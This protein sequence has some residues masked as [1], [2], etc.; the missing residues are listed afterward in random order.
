MSLPVQNAVD[1]A[2]HN[3]E[4]I[5]LLINKKGFSSFGICGHCGHTL[6]CPRCDVHLTYTYHQKVVYCRYCAHTQDKPA[7]CPQCQKTY[8]HFKGGGIE[9]L[10]SEVARHF[11]CARIVRYE[12]KTQA[13]PHQADIVI[14]TQAVLGLLGKMTFSLSVAMQID[15]QLDRP[16]YKAGYHAFALLSQ[17]GNMTQD[18]LLIQTRL[19]NND[20]L[21]AVQAQDPD[22]FY[23]QD[24]KLRKDLNLRPF[25]HLAEIIIRGTDQ[26][27]VAQ[28]AE[29]FFAILQ[30]QERGKNIDIF[31]PQA[32]AMAKLRDQYRFAIVIR[33][34]SATKITDLVRKALKSFRKKAGV[35]LTVNIDP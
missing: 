18:R 11:P 33:G 31:E 3:K 13:I 10:E 7:F 15:A 26:D 28:Q 24:M 5:L 8:I 9:K 19:K 12:E 20:C 30:K 6:K 22:R 4:K 25:G 29:D 34:S 35:L 32:A 14:A 21:C 17:I 23:K 27:K 16:D 1:K 2:L